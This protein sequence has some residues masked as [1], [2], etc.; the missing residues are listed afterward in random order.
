L[1]FTPVMRI[2]Y[3]IGLLYKIFGDDGQCE[4][5][6]KEVYRRCL[7]HLPE[8]DRKTAQVRSLLQSM[9]VS[10]EEPPQPLR[11]GRDNED[12]EGEGEESLGQLG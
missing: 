4:A 5:Y 1:V 7:K 9:N 11:L 3:S 8:H 12:E 6:L 2:Y 10:L